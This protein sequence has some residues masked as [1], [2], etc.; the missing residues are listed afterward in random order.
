MEKFFYSA[1]ILLSEHAKEETTTIQILKT[2]DFHHQ[3]YGKFA[4]TTD[5]MDSMILNFPGPDRLPLDYNHG[6]MNP[7]PNKSKAAG[8]IEKIY[9][10]NEDGEEKLMADV[11]FTMQAKEFVENGE[12]KYISPE[13]TMNRMNKETG[14]PQGPTLLAAALTNRPFLPSMAPITLND[15]GWIEEQISESEGDREMTLEDQNIL[16]NKI[17]SAVQ[18]LIGLNSDESLSQKLRT[19]T[20]GFY[21]EYPDTELTSYVVKDVRDDNIIVEMMRRN[22]GSKMFQVGYTST[23]DSD[24][25]IEFNAP[26]QWQEV[27]R[28]YEPVGQNAMTEPTISSSEKE[29]PRMDKELLKLLG[30]KEDAEDS[31]VAEAVAALVDKAEQVDQLELSI[32]EMEGKVSELTEMS[33]EESDSEV[34]LSDDDS[35]VILSEQNSELTAK[36][37]DVEEENVR[38]AD[39]LKVLMDDKR[40]READ[41]RVS[42]A[43]MNRKL[44]PAEV[45]GADAPMRKLALNDPE[46]F[47]AIINAKPAYDNAILELTSDNDATVPAS[48]SEEESVDE[49]W[50]LW[51][52]L[53]AD[54]PSL[55]SHEV[56]GMIDRDHPEIAQA[57]GI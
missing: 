23:G 10:I 13:F 44:L 4:V 42:S 34:A 14:V 33:E 43:V 32:K 53:S 56:R 38:L 9:K 12:F 27:R 29:I 21:K 11:K 3:K 6:S 50:K 1:E 26:N 22:E 24:N 45:D 51:D 55:K 19:V 41:D 39:Q 36:L 5:V 18:H 20:K 7:D 37:S 49:Y 54:N 28:T 16:E 40:M 35:V 15:S 31:A 2:G 17:A 8:W 47:D 57:A 25:A 48:Q 30:L 46:S 52:K